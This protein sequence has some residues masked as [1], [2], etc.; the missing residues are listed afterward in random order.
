[1]APPT[2]RHEWP[3]PDRQP[4]RCPARGLAA[5]SHP[6]RAGGFDRSKRCAVDQPGASFP[7]PGESRRPEGP[8]RR[9]SAAVWTDNSNAH[10]RLD[11]QSNVLEQSPAAGIATD[12][13]KFNELFRA[14]FRCGKVNGRGVNAAARIEIR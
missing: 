3:V 9:L 4:N 5:I 1:I 13:F 10:A 11:S 8:E 7:R 12:I 2:L 6:A 14:A